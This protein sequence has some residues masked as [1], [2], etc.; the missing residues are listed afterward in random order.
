MT[1]FRKNERASGR[2]WGQ[3]TAYTSLLSMQKLLQCPHT[4]RVSDTQPHPV[5]F[6]DAEKKKWPVEN[7]DP[8]AGFKFC[9]CLS[10][11]S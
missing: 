2:V 7:L 9:P 10:D 1:V 4:I 8:G 6:V 3:G 5:S 11:R